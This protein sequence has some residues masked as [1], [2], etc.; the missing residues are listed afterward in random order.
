MCIWV[1]F[2]DCRKPQTGF[3]D[4]VSADFDARDLVTA[5][6]CLY[7]KSRHRCRDD[8]AHQ[9]SSSYRRLKENAFTNDVSKDRSQEIF[10]SPETRPCYSQWNIIP[11]M[12]SNPVACHVLTVIL[13]WI[14]VEQ[15]HAAI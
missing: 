1:C 12:N 3:R 15:A 4:L 8:I 6:E 11:E 9:T 7:F 14:F 2:K 10:F 5:F 13:S